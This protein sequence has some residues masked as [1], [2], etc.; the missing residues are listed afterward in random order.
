MAALGEAQSSTHV[1]SMRMA[2]RRHI[3]Q[4]GVYAVHRLTMQDGS[5]VLEYASSGGVVFAVSWKTQYK[6]NVA[7]LL[8][9]SYPSYA[10][11]VRAQGQRGGSQRHFLHEGSDLVVKSHAH[12]NVFSGVAYRRSLLP[13]GLRPD[14]IE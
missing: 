11:A 5:Q 9:S 1:D 4:K 7:A 12:L 13:A 10:V 14:Q 8:G 6:P 3:D 2:A